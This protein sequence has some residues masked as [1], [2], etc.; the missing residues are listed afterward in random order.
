MTTKAKQVDSSDDEGELNPTVLKTA[1]EIAESNPWSLELSSDVNSFISGFRKY[2]SD[3]NDNKPS[4]E[5]K[6]TPNPEPEPIKA[7]AEKRQATKPSKGNE[8]P[9]PEPTTVTTKKRPAAKSSKGS[10]EGK[11]MKLGACSKWTVTP[12]ATDSHPLRKKVTD[13]D[14][15]EAF[16]LADEKLAANI[17]KKFKVLSG[18]IKPAPAGFQKRSVKKKKTSEPSLK[19]KHSRWHVDRAQV[20]QELGDTTMEDQPSSLSAG[21]SRAERADSPVEVNPSQI[22]ID[23]DKFIKVAPK[24]V[25]TP[26]PEDVAGGD[27]D[28]LDEDEQQQVIME[29]FADDNVVDFK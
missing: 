13:L 23:P 2:W 17:S 25:N 1:L 28:A 9:E 19:M 24:S 11:K 21:R 7:T 12:V 5:K 18:K 6:E 26:V 10:E 27:D 3:K 20:D 8:N 14:L 22:N 29:A 4:E 15:D 16:Y